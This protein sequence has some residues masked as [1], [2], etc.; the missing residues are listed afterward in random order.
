MPAKPFTI[1]V[2][3]TLLKRIRGRARLAKRTV[4]AEVI[5]LLSDAVAQPNGVE[6]LP[7]KEQ[8]GARKD[9]MRNGKPSRITQS[10]DEELP[11]DIVEAMA[12]IERLDTAALHKAVKP[13]MTTKQAN[14]AAALNYKA[15]A[16]GLTDAE[17]KERDELMHVYNKSVLVRSAA[18]AELH[19]RGVNV[20]ELI[21]KEAK[22]R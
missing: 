16:E 11:P 7:G 8:P 9:N 10:E 18:F 15:Q 1:A 14:R 4:E 2:P 21:A 6:N 12:K 22:R 13:L 17:E 20:N 5:Q 3:E 19:K